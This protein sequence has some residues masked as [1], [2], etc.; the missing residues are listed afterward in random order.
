[1]DVETIDLSMDMEIAM[2]MDRFDRPSSPHNT[3]ET[4]ICIDSSEDE[5]N[6]DNEGEQKIPGVAAAA[7]ASATRR[8][9]GPSNIRRFSSAAEAA[10]YF[11][12]TPNTTAGRFGGH[13]KHSK[14]SFAASA[15]AAAAA[16]REYARKV[17]MSP[18]N[19]PGNNTSINS[20][21]SYECNHCTE[22]FRTFVR[23]MRHERKCKK[24]Q[25]QKVK[26][27]KKGKVKAENGEQQKEAKEK[28]EGDDVEEAEEITYTS[29]RPTKLKYGKDHPDPVVENS[30][31]SAVQP[32]DVTYNLA[33]PASILAEGKLSNLQL[34]AIVYGCQRHLVDLPMEDR[35]KDPFA[36]EE[37][38][39]EAKPLRAGF[40]LGDGAGMGKGRTLAG[41]VVENIARGRKRHVWISVSSDL[42]EDAKR[43]LCDLG[44]D[45]YADENCFNLGKLPY[46]D[47]TKNYPEGVM[48]ATYQTLISKNR[49]KD[50]RFDQL[51][52]W[53]GGDDFDG[54][55]ML[56]E[57]H[58]AKNIELDADGKPKMAGKGMDRREKSSKTATAVVQLQQAMPRARVVYCSA[59][60]VSQPKNLG[61]MS[62]LGLWGY[63][64]EH[65]SGFNQFLDGLKRLG[66]GAME[67][68]S[69]LL[70]YCTYE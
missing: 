1:M 50:T 13:T 15:A 62:R 2:A 69:N 64:T 34:E 68:R 19:T 51:L 7:S 48:F 46:G 9:N 22:K 30:T 38:Q 29:Y 41:F 21:L 42:Y 26:A 66:T 53:C 23:K 16:R 43:D 58:K 32:P 47:L 37:D 45:S 12:Y 8:T 20:S 25:M 27:E 31:L 57:C 6:K 17:S 39:V 3:K 44:L 40:L 35:K 63:G 10:Q 28:E 18:T 70:L 11:N 14:Q 24:K 59:T 56:D 36:P 5:E 52:K 60:S 67:V 33:M 4:A 54:L 49:N 55:V 65:P 61:F